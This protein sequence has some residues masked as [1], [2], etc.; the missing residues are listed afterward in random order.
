MASPVFPRDVQQVYFTPIEHFDAERYIIDNIG[1][2]NLSGFELWAFNAKTPVKYDESVRFLWNKAH[3]GVPL[4]GSY[5]TTIMRMV[6][7][8][9]ERFKND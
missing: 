8:W 6:D 7:Y 1:N 2:D 3:R 5:K 9:N 4:I